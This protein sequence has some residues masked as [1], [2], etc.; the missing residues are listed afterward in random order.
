MG[1][2]NIGIFSKKPEDSLNKIVSFTIA[3]QIAQELEKKGINTSIEMVGTGK[4]TV[5]EYIPYK[6]KR[7]ER[8]NFKQSISENGQLKGIDETVKEIKV[9]M[10]KTY[11]P[12]DYSR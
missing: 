11:K 9:Q 7:V 3:N 2:F 10:P 12:C 4:Y 8:L 5:K 1:I 6:T